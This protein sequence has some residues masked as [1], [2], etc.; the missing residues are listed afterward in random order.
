MKISKKAILATAI[1]ATAVLTTACGSRVNLKENYSQYDVKK[2]C[3]LSVYNNQR[4]GK[5]ENLALEKFIKNSFDKL[6]I[7]SKI[8]SS[9]EE[10]RDSDCTHYFTYSTKQKN[11]PYTQKTSYKFYEVNHK[12]TKFFALANIGLKEKIYFDGSNGAQDLV[13]KVVNTLVTRDTKATF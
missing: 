3:I 7:P 8:V 9:T 4:I 1:V 6:A 12:S 10:A 11:T 2:V 13:D 5:N